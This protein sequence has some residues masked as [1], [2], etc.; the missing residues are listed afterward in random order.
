MLWLVLAAW[1]RSL[2][3]DQGGCRSR[4]CRAAA[5]CGDTY[6]SPGELQGEQTERIAVIPPCAVDLYNRCLWPMNMRPHCL[7]ASVCP[8][9][10]SAPAGPHRYS[11]AASRR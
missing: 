2:G 1:P 10:S 5:R 9:H 11:L 4:Y 8:M 3:R 6:H 7:I